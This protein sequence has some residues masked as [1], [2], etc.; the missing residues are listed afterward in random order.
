MKIFV[1]PDKDKG[2][3]HNCGNTLQG[4]KMRA[5]CL[6][7]PG[8]VILITIGMLANPGYAGID[9]DTIIGLWLFNE[10]NGDEVMDTWENELTGVAVDGELKWV[11]GKFGGA[12]AFAGGIRVQVEHNDILTLETFTM[13]L[14]VNPESTGGAEKRKKITNDTNGRIAQIICDI[15]AMAWYA[16]PFGQNY[17]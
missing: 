17:I 7:V 16:T 11:E 6:L 5:K 9:P 13:T 15:D 2:M 3:V 1:F 10:D 12:L 4:G 14:W 8:A